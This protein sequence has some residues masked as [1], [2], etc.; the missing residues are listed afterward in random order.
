[1]KIRDLNRK[2]IL[3]CKEAGL[4]AEWGDYF[5]HGVENAVL[6]TASNPK[7]TFGGGIDAAFYD[8]FPELCQ[9]KQDKSGGMERIGNIVFCITVDEHYR[10]AKEIVKKAVQF[11]ASQLKEEET[12]IVHGAGCGIGGLA[13]ADFVEIIK[14]TENV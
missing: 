7:W 1:M 3:A 11:A 10:A 14:E 12:L 8:H 4:D 5:S 2:L 6:M 13:I 9:E